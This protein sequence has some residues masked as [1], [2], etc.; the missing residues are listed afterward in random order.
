MV[1]V[2]SARVQVAGRNQGMGQRGGAIGFV[3][4]KTA[5]R[6]K[7][8]IEVDFLSTFRLLIF[9]LSPPPH[10]N[11]SRADTPVRR[12]LVVSPLTTLARPSVPLLVPDPTVPH[13][14]YSL[15]GT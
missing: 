13:Y 8:Q 5:E 9:F 2:R 1:Q 14:R 6:T 7:E 3:S 4:N 11:T 12:S 10:R 15:Y